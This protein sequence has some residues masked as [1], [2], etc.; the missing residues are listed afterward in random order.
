MIDWKTHPAFDGHEDV[1]EVG[2]EALGFAGFVAIHSTVMGPA[3]GGCRIWSY[4]RAEDALTDVLRLSR[5]MTYKNTMAE[6]PLGGG[7]TV[8]YR[9]GPD[10]AACLE[11]FGEQVEAIGGRYITAEDV[12]ASVEDMLSVARRTSYVV[13]LPKEAAGQAGGDPSPITARGVF[14]CIEAL[15]GGDVAGKR[16]A[17]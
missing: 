4:D 3:T 5:G 14:Y 17:V 8:L 12:G 2:D 6:L 13:G 9:M 11:K 7:K 10:R 15:L 1:I 16:V